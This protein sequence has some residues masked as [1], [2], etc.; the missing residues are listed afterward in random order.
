MKKIVLIFI[1]MLLT[2]ISPVTA[3]LVQIESNSVKS[4]LPDYFNWR[5]IDGTDFTTSI[6]TQGLCP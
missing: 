1:I 3:E 5:D 4:K 6:K 2:N